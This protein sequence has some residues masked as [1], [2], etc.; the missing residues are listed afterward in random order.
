MA[1]KIGIIGLGNVGAALAHSLICQGMAESYVFIDV[2]EEKSQA[3]AL[4]FEDAMANLKQFA[5]IEVN[6]YQALADADIVVSALGNI[7]LQHNAGEDRFAEFPFTKLAVKE[8]SKRLV[9]VGFKGILLVITNPCDA[10]CALYQHY[11]GFPKEKVFGTG[12]LLDTAR[13]KRA[14]GKAFE[15]N[16][17][18]VSGYNLGEHGNSQFVAWSQ[19]SL[20]GQSIMDL[21]TRDQREELNLAAVKGGHTVFYG[22]GYTSFG[23]A[24]SACRLIEQILT[25]AKEVL[26]VSSYQEKFQT[27]LGYPAIIGRDGIVERVELNLTEEEEI[28]LAASAKLIKER[29]EAVLAE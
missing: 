7:A 15:V 19:V 13:M 12:T 26:P 6:D 11:T 22:K 8:V 27:Y 20:K 1:R 2:S 18:S 14:L 17:K 5:H 29:V 25:D 16:P 4:D 28:K 10:V 9:E 21:T 23:I 24:A 3:D